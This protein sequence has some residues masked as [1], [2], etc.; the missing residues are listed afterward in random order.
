MFSS[1][2]RY[3]HAQVRFSGLRFDKLEGIF[4]RASTDGAIKLE[5]GTEFQKFGNVVAEYLRDTLISVVK[6]QAEGALNRAIKS[7]FP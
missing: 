5:A 7:L 1:F 6:T 4:S 2:R 3:P